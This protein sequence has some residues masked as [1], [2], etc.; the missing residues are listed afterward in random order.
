MDSTQLPGQSFKELVRLAKLFNIHGLYPIIVGGWAV[1]YYTKGAGSIDIDLVIPT[2]QGV[3]AFEKYSKQY[4]FKRGRKAK[5]RELFTKETI[6]GEIE[7]DIFTFSHKNLLASNKSIEVPWKLAEE[8]PQKW[9]LG[10]GV[11]ARVPEKE[12]LLLYK[13]AAL[14]DRKYKIKNWANLSKFARD[15]LKAKIAKDKKDIHG[16]LEKGI[17]SKRLQQLLK[18]TKFERQ[19]GE[20]VGKIRNQ[21][22]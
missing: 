4:G 3:H 11:I 16:L 20:T 17:D 15:R 9:A 7:L 2:K 14:S 1:Y 12:V 10:K 22:K 13:A 8:N 5:T 6:A 19:F 18:K 21:T